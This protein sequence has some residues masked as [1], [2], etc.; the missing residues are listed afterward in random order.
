MP[1]LRMSLQLISVDLIDGSGNVADMWLVSLSS[2]IC[3]VSDLSGCS[4]FMNQFAPHGRF[5]G[6]YGHDQ[7]LGFGTTTFFEEICS[8]FILINLHA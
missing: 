8:L 7:K 2:H 6:V 3:G 5:C 4:R 1:E